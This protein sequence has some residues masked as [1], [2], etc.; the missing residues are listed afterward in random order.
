L[1]AHVITK[2]RLTVLLFT[3]L[4]CASP[5]AFGADYGASSETSVTNENRDQDRFFRRVIFEGSLANAG[6][7]GGG[8]SRYSNPNGYSA[9]VLLDLL[10]RGGLVLETGAVYRQFGTT[11]N[12]GVGD[13][14]FTANYIS[15]PVDVKYY[16]SGQ[17]TTSLYFK[18]GVMGSTLISNNT[19]YSTPTT[20][21]G[22]RSWETALLG[23]L[24]VKFN[25]SSATDLL[26]EA[27]YSRSV[28]SVFNDANVYRSD[29]SAALGL[30][31]N[32]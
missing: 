22:A 19:M 15:I 18:A 17:E 26:L 4:S 9:G 7:Q 14:K 31:I 23:G 8:S 5:S 2:Y 25:L 3:F 6:Y 32:L 1:E 16:L 12:N 11:Y 21:I 29:L 28:D 27:D 30:A 10:G 24:G 20:Q 13:N